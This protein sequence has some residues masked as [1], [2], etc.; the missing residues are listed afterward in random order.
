M[1]IFRGRRASREPLPTEHSHSDISMRS[2]VALLLTLAVSTA[3]AQ[4][5]CGKY[6]ASVRVDTAKHE[7]IITA[8]PFDLKPMPPMQGHGADVM[9]MAETL[10]MRFEWPV[11]GSL[12]GVDLT[13]SDS[14][15]HAVPTEVLHHLAMYNFDRRGLIHTSVER[16]FAWG[17][18]TRAIVLPAGVAAPV[19]KGEHLG[20]LIGWHNET[21]RA[22][23]GATVHM[24]LSYVS[25]K[26]VKA[27]VM[28]WYLDMHMVYGPGGNSFDLPVGRST[29]RFDF[30]VPVSG[31]LIAV[32][33]HMHD[34]AQWVSL[35]DSATG[36]TLV[37]L[38]A[39]RDKQGSVTG[40]GRFVFGFNEDALPI[41]ANHTYT[42]VSQYDNA[43]GKVIKDGGMSQL[44]GVFEPLDAAQYPRLDMSDPRTIADLKSLP[45]DVGSP[46]AQNYCKAQGDMDHDQMDMKDMKDMKMDSVVKQDSSPR[47]PPAA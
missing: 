23:H 9:K 6:R 36:K 15:G 45:P 28:P 27:S 1:A 16:L 42:L 20:F 35:V 22:I 33:G 26:K 13:I 25:P 30:Q 18:D 7:V 43:T 37:K 32:G 41:Q 24:T 19:P 31:R 17:Q 4:E 21:G 11:A 3:G 14:L 5:N 8:G 47:K 29:Q 34:H 44:N 2:I 39:E 12:S 46:D 38:Q 10:M 40:T